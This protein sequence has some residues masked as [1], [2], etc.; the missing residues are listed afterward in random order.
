MIPDKRLFIDWRMD[1]PHAKDTAFLSPSSYIH[2]S[3]LSSHI[4]DE[5]YGQG[6]PISSFTNVFVN[7]PVVM[8]LF[9]WATNS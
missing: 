3:D 2:L 8:K 6:L 9:I 4:F 1:E 5:E 7:C